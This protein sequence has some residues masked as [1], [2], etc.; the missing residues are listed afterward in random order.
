MSDLTTS[1]TEKL[2]ADL[3][4]VIGDTEELLKATANQAGAGASELRARLTER[5]HQARLRLAEVQ[6]SAVQRAK[7]AGHKADDYVH[8]HP[9][10][11]VATAAGVGLVVGLLI[12]RR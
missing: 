7:A 8:D 12:G 2:A 4:T 1:Q 11:A 6:D 5:M 9:W 10:R 3:R